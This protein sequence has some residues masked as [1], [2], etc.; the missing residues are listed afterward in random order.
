MV[1]RKFKMAGL[2]AGVGGIELGFEKAGFEPV[3]ANEI[4]E[5]ASITYMANH[6]HKLITKDVNKLGA[7][8]IPKID[9]LAGGF[10]CQAFSV[11]GYRKGFKDPRG[12]VFWE[13]IR[14]LEDKK[15]QVVFLENVKNLT[16]HDSG[17]TF[18]IIRESLAEIG[19]YIH[20]A[21]LNASEYGGVPQNRERIYVVGFRNKKSFNNF[22][23]PGPMKKKPNLKDFIYFDK[24]V[25]DVYYYEDRY[26]SK[27]LRKTITRSDTVY[28][29]RRQYVRENKSNLCP[30]LTANMGTGG[31]NVPL[32]FTKYGIRKLTPRE[33][34]N[35]M[36][37]PKNFRLPKELALGH[38]YKQAGNAVVVGVVER[39][40]INI[41]AA[42]NNE[43]MASFDT[44]VQ[45]KLL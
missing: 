8:E 43:P 6:K 11:A 25:D 29:W 23:F 38:L 40:A 17:K 16:S 39:I 18:R 4:D 20:F 15:P 27:L 2:F 12:N 10:P 22:L 1:S 36:G 32:I 42:L 44:D 31:H 9:V 26:M 24:K 5:K 45:L 33:C 14:L 13:I 37:F 34:F 35:L 19:Y 30:T 41:L 21:V 3:F 7:F 28:Q